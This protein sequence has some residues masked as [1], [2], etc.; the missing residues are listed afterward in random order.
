MIFKTIVS[1]AKG[2]KDL[3]FLARIVCFVFMLTIKREIRYKSY[4]IV[5]N[6]N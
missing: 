4:T 1:G 6:I 3:E 2:M 5:H